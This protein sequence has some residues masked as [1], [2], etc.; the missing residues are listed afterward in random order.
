M[1]I[2]CANMFKADELRTKAEPISEGQ[3][4]MMEAYQSVL[5]IDESIEINDNFFDLGGDSLLAMK[6]AASI[7]AIYMTSW[8][9]QL[10]HH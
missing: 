3:T 1:I 10:L 9:I 6:L 7:N 4:K 2:L 8:S 5:N